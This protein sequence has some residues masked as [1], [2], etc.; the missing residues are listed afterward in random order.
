MA[1][2]AINNTQLS[3]NTAAA[4][5]TAVAV[6]AADGALITPGDASRTLIILENAAVSAKN[7][8]IVAGNGFFGMDDTVVSVPG[9]GRLVLQVQSGRFVNFSGPNK[10]CILVKGADADIRVACLLLP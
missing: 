5:P 10:G 3:W 6:D 1:S 7:A 8:T 4:L 9:N 2:V